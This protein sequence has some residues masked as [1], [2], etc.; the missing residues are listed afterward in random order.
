MNY[1]DK[2]YEG[3]ILPELPPKEGFKHNLQYFLG[4][5]EA[6]LNERQLKL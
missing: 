1:L 2:K 6:F 5:D 3:F 4:L